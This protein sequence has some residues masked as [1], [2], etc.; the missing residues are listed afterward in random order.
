MVR[1]SL[2]RARAFPVAAATAALLRRFIYVASLSLA[3]SLPFVEAADPGA[4]VIVMSA[5][6]FIYANESLP[7]YVIVENKGEDAIERADVVSVDSE[8]FTIEP[9]GSAARLVAIGPAETA[10]IN[11]RATPRAELK[12]G[13]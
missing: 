3:T 9:G 11:F 7:I 6:D 10:V 2:D 8:F 12:P 1:R 13:S 5:V 4:S